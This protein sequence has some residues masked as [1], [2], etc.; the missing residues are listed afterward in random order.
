MRDIFIINSLSRTAKTLSIYMYF[1]LLILAINSIKSF[2][3]SVFDS[4][5][6]YIFKMDPYVNS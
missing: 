2:N 5:F 6:F 3:I 1:I 4:L